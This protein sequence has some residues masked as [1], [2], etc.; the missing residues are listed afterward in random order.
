[1]PVSR[2]AV[3]RKEATRQPMNSKEAAL[4]SCIVEAWPAGFGN[5]LFGACG[6]PI[7]APGVRANARVPATDIAWREFDLI[8]DRFETNE[9][10][11]RLIVEL[12]N[13]GLG[14]RSMSQVIFYKHAL[15]PRHTN[16]F[17]ASRFIFV[18]IG[19]QPN[20]KRWHGDGVLESD[21]VA[22][23]ELLSERC[24]PDPDVYAFSYQQLG[25]LWS[26]NEQAWSWSIA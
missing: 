22:F 20:P 2:K 10:W 18:A 14:Y 16:F 19:K 17:D 6:L 8:T 24:W 23:L 1:M 3:K 4:T 9:E 12:K 26:A 25:L 5:H 11:C 21:A 13:G 7:P 15:V